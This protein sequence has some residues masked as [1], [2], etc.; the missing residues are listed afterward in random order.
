MMGWAPTASLGSLATL[1]RSAFRPVDAFRTNL[2][3]DG[4]SEVQCFTQDSDLIQSACIR[5]RGL[6]IDA[7]TNLHRR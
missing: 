7:F 1:G 2:K 5:R 4:R 3:P 6:D